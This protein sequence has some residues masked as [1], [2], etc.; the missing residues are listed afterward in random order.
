MDEA[1]FRRA[2]L[3]DPAAREQSQRLAQAFSEAD[4]ER[5]KAALEAGDIAA[6]QNEL[7]LS[8]AEF[9]EIADALAQARRSALEQA[10]GAMPAG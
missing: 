2:L 8:D 10:S 4:P 1:E 5:L 6:F 7:G 9:V 3:A